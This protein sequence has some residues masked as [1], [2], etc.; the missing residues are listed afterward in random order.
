MY[1]GTYNVYVYHTN[2]FL[3]WSCY[4]KNSA[5]EVSTSTHMSFGL[6]HMY[7]QICCG[8]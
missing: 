7:M 1:D 8:Y 5:F 4:N 2:S 6:D 3:A